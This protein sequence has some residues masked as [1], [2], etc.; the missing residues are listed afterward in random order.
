MMRLDH[1]PENVQHRS[2]GPGIKFQEEAQALGYG[3]HPL[4]DR[5]GWEDLIVQVHGGL[6]HAPGLSRGTEGAGGV[7][8]ASHG[9]NPLE[10]QH[11]A[12]VFQDIPK[13]Y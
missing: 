4:A 6:G 3:Q 12:Q 5:Q 11:C 13:D 9:P 2:H 10:V 1:L 7:T 8:P